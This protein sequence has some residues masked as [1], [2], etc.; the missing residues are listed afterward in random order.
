MMFSQ[1]FGLKRLTHEYDISTASRIIIDVVWQ[2][3]DVFTGTDMHAVLSG[4]LLKKS[5]LDSIGLLSALPHIS[6]CG[7][8]IEVVDRP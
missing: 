8:V 3:T 5:S 7:C 6:E 1:S 4:T 2:M